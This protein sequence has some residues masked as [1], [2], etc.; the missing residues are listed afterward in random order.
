MSRHKL[1]KL[2]LE[3]EQLMACEK[4][5]S[6]A[7]MSA[8]NASLM[9]SGKT[10]MATEVVLASKAQVILIIGPLNTYWGWWD[11]IQRQT[12][13]ES[14]V[15]RI[16]SSKDGKQAMQD[17]ID[18]KPGWYFIGREYFR[19]KDWSKVNTIQ[20]ALVD[21]V[22]SFQN[23]NSKGFKALKSLKSE[24]KLAMS[25]TPFG[26]KF[27][28]AWAVTKWLWKDRVPNSF[29]TWANEW[30][31]MAYS[32]FTKYEIVGEKHP[33]AYAANLPCYVR[34][35]PNH[36]LEVIEETI[37]V[38]LVPAQKKI[39]QKFQKD[40]VV[41]L[42]DNPLVA[43]VPIAARI[44]L[45]QMTLAVPSV[46]EEGGIYFEED[47]VSTKWNALSDLIDDNPGEPMFILTDSQ[48]YA[49]I[50]TQRLNKKFKSEVAFEWSGQATQK[51]REIAKQAFLAGQLQFIVAVIP[52]IAEGVDGLQNACSTVVWLSHSDNNLMN[53]QVLD[54]IRRRGQ[55]NA[56]R[57]YDIVARDT[58]DEGQL[59]TLL[60]RQLQMNATLKGGKVGQDE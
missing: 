24:R 34:I 8:L 30:C 53:Q 22:Q 57:V 60:T 52:A 33:G 50:V 26:N 2:T 14:N 1:P 35:E 5:M 42:K 37:Y 48:K 13:Y 28:G 29:W 40:L 18:G 12:D 23:R 10:L 49:R 17:M 20:Y 32:P 36:N 4:I 39:Y 15:V 43:E 44:R 41:W 51:Q 25:G 59:D 46:D 19:T 47:S 45:R 6:E 38:D 7:T 11:T 9:G 3:P 21:E 56:V 54:R 55:K 16:D 31:E 27:E 58:Y